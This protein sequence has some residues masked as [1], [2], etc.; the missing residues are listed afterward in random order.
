MRAERIGCT[1]PCPCGDFSAAV[2][3]NEGND[4]DDGE[5]TA[6]SEPESAAARVTWDAAVRAGEVSGPRH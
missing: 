1:C 5:W 4:E 3:K 2:V 6:D